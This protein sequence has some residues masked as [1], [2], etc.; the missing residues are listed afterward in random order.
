MRYVFGLWL[1]GIAFLAPNF[2]LHA[3][4]F[5]LS[6]LP[7]VGTNPVQV[8]VADVN[9]DGKMDLLSVS[10]ITNLI[11]VLTNSGNGSFG[12][13]T[14]IKAGVTGF[15]ANAFTTADVNGDGKPDLTCA[16]STGNPN[17]IGR[18]LVFTNDGGGIFVSNT[19]LAVGTNPVSVVAA[20]LNGDGLMDLVTA[21]AG[22]LPNYHTVSILTNNGDGNFVS[23]A[24]I[25][26]GSG[27]LCVIAADV[28]GDGKVDLITANF[29]DGKLSVL[30]NNGA[31]RFTLAASPG[32]GSYPMMVLAAD[33]NGD[34]KVDLVSANSGDDTLSILTN[35]GSGTFTLSSS[36]GVGFTPYSVIAADVNGD[37]WVDLVSVNKNGGTLTVL[38][39]N[40]SGG[41]VVAG[42]P[43]TG[44]RPFSVAAADVS[45]DGRLDL[46][47]AN[48]GTNSLSVLT[49]SLNFLPRLVFKRSG[50]N[51][52][53][54]WPSSWTGWAGWTLQQNTTVN[55]AGWTGFSG[56]IGDNGTTKAVT[57]S[58]AAGNAFFRLWH[59]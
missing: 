48:T 25:N 38:T 2:Q 17:Y 23:N 21:N 42:S 46:I 56:G 18:L 34:G 28:N 49:N 15:Y 26:V 58:L 33:V 36:P 20:D 40:G 44:N 6:A 57:N 12:F 27:P 51:L 50:N 45:G 8:V 7:V 55:G 52:I 22:A 37:G 16:L 41:F 24:T 29:Y 3:Q 59:P 9:M 54:S 47:S 14:T 30:L 39:N 4:S 1:A 43:V 32:V 13:D 19:M 11:T 31:G 5:S 10:G 35:N 53:V